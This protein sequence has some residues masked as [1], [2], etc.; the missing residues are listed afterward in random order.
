MLFLSTARAVK[1][2]KWH[3]SDLALWSLSSIYVR[4]WS[5]RWP[6]YTFSYLFAVVLWFTDLSLPLSPLFPV[7]C[8]FA[9]PLLRFFSSVP[10]LYSL[11]FYASSSSSV[12]N[13][14]RCICDDLL[15]FL[16][17]SSSYP[18]PNRNDL[19]ILVIL[20]HPSLELPRLNKNTP[21]FCAWPSENTLFFVKGDN[22]VGS[23]AVRIIVIFMTEHFICLLFIILVPRT[24]SWSVYHFSR[25]DSTFGFVYILPY[26]VCIAVLN[27]CEFRPFLSVF[28]VI[29]FS[30]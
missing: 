25:N 27:V 23:V 20:Y 5:E 21:I 28:H 4:I 18:H 7:L 19:C 9:S 3:C 15:D 8:L 1:S 30:P 2:T 13:L 22:V 10:R 17:L 29:V 6:F 11:F 14:L 12:T 16:L 26:L 24:L